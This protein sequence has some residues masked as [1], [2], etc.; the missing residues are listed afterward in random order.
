MSRRIWAI[1]D[2]SICRRCRRSGPSGIQKAE[3]LFVDG[4]VDHT[5]QADLILEGLQAARNSSVPSFF[6]PGP[7][8][9]ALD[10]AWHAAAC[11]RTTVVLATEDEA[12]RISGRSDPLELARAILA[13]G[14]ELVVIKRGVAGCFLVRKDEVHLAGGYPVDALDTTGAG[15]S[16]DAAVIDAYLRRLPLAAIGTLANAVGAAKVWSRK[17]PALARDSDKRG[18]APRPVLAGGYPV[19][20]LDTTGAGDSLDAAVIDGYLRR[21]PLPALGTLA[22]AVGAAK[23]LKLGTGRSVPTR[24]RSSRRAETLRRGRR[25]APSD[26]TGPPLPSGRRCPCRGARGRG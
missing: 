23:V 11:R 21:L 7:G 8:N 5:R 25:R 19:D 10:N 18:P 6:D 26:V 16:L 15:D 14:P 13:L 20:A 3:A 22:N 12:Q 2:A 4:W 9:P 17:R 24:E 1:R